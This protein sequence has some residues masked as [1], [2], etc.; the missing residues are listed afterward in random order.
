MER[1]QCVGIRKSN[2]LTIRYAMRHPDKRPKGRKLKPMRKWLYDK[3]DRKW[4]R[5]RTA[6]N[7]FI[8]DIARL[9]R[10]KVRMTVPDCPM[11]RWK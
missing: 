1:R 7:E 8:I 6:L 9:R 5:M 2:E 4:E 3:M 11:L 10:P